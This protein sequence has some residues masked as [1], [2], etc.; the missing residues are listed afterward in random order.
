MLSAVANPFGAAIGDVLAPALVSRPEDIGFLLLVIAIIS[1]AVFPL[2][3]LIYSQPPTPPSKS[4]AER[5]SMESGH[6]QVW[7]SIKVLLGL[8][9]SEVERRDLI[10]F[11]IIA[12]LFSVLIGFL[13]VH[14]FC[15]PRFWIWLIRG[16]SD[17]FLTLINQ[18]F[19][20]VGYNSD[21]AGCIG[22]ATIFSG[23]VAFVPPL[24]LLP[25]SLT[26]PVHSALI[27]APLFDRFL[28]FRLAQTTKI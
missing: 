27:S 1:T 19:E 18:L 15:Y 3:F 16:D 12:F 10:D 20:P 5:L 14:L 13:F 24:S 7:R 23:L 4:A 6:R 8:N 9:P 11:W 2:V 17:A 25:A 21:I 26:L 28:K 22:A